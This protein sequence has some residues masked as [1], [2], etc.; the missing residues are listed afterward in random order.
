MSNTAKLYLTDKQEELLD[1]L[2]NTLSDSLGQLRAD[3]TL[4]AHPTHWCQH[5]QQPQRYL[6]SGALERWCREF[7][8]VLETLTEKLWGLEEEAIWKCPDQAQYFGDRWT[9][10]MMELLQQISERGAARALRYQPP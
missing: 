8:Q 1:T 9:L 7:F 3:K 2:A 6:P 10:V 5:K 4:E